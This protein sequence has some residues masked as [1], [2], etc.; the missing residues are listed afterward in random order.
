VKTDE[1]IFHNIVVTNV[2]SG[3]MTFLDIAERI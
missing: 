2:S 3:L 1:Y